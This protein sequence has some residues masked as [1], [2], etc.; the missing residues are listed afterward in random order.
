[1]DKQ[2]Y[3]MEFKDKEESIEYIVIDELIGILTKRY[4]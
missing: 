1:M 4:P 2:I 3:D